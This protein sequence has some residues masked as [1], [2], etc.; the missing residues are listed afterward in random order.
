M[1]G[2]ENAPESASSAV[3]WVK[4]SQNENPRLEFQPGSVARIFRL[5]GTDRSVID[6]DAVLTNASMKVAEAVL[7]KDF[8]RAFS[9][10]AGMMNRAVDNTRRKT[11]GKPSTTVLPAFRA[12]VDRALSHFLAET[13]PNSRIA[14]TPQAAEIIASLA[15]KQAGV[16]VLAS[17]TAL[18]R[19]S[20]MT[21]DEQQAMDGINSR[22]AG[23]EGGVRRA[24]EEK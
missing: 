4:G 19:V 11:A 2:L 5:P 7:P 1:G 18:D 22:S 21:P 15:E 16:V 6:I 20:S 14:L 8:D 10:L 12:E 9:T 17:N 3:E 23:S 13:A 24:F